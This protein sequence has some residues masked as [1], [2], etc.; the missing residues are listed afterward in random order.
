MSSPNSKKETVATEAKRNT[1]KNTRILRT[2]KTFTIS[3][4]QY[5][6]TGTTKKQTKFFYRLLFKKEDTT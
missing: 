5:Q 4:D 6:I 1:K 3:Q 2:V